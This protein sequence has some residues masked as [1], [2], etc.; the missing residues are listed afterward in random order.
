MT[1]V[2]NLL[3]RAVLIDLKVIL[4]E[5][6]NRGAFVV[7][8]GRVQDHAGDTHTDFERVNRSK[9]SSRSFLRAGHIGQGQ[10][11]NQRDQASARGGTCLPRAYSR[12]E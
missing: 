4:A 11:E 2:F 1:V 10:Q 12:V 3:Q 9:L 5:P 8:H 6:R 7:L